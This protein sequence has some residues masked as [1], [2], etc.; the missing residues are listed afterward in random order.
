MKN[1]QVSLSTGYLVC[2]ILS[3]PVVLRKRG[4]NKTNNKYLRTLQG[5]IKTKG[6]QDWKQILDKQK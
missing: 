2:V 3:L 4:K 1:K 6:A 5:E